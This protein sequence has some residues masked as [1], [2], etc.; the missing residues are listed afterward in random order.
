MSDQ[1]ERVR[2]VLNH[3]APSTSSPFPPPNDK[4]NAVKL[5]S[6][7]VSRKM[8]NGQEETKQ[9]TAFYARV[10]RAMKVLRIWACTMPLRLCMLPISE[11]SEIICYLDFQLGEKTRNR[12]IFPRF[13]GF[14]DNSTSKFSHE[15]F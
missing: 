3:L 2:Q 4:R 1:P 15:H 8:V 14:S 5:N 7:M 11:H 6:K 9:L 13:H 10:F 12:T